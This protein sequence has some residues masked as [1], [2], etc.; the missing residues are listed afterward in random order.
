MGLQGFLPNPKLALA[1]ASA[2]TEA[3]IDEYIALVSG[4]E[5]PP[6]PF[7]R[8]AVVRADGRAR[9]YLF[10]SLSKQD[11]RRQRDLAE[12]CPVPLAMVNGGADPFVDVAYVATVNYRNLWSGRTYVLTGVGHAPH[13]HAPERFNRLLERFLETVCRT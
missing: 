7:W 1:G 11:A 3:E 8:A 12:R 5:A 6:D 2:M 10:E 9:A 4:F 13:I